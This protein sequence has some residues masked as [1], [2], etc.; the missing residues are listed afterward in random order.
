VLST[1]SGHWPTQFLQ[2]AASTLLIVVMGRALRT[3]A[4][5][6]T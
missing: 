4:A 5:A 6:P 3:P 1:Q 2:Y